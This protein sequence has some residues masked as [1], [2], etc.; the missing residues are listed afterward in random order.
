MSRP[1]VSMVVAIARNGVIGR[2][3]DLPWHQS[4][5]LRRF[6]AI[7]M[8]KPMLMGRKCFDSFGGR[9]LPG[10]P[11][12][13]ITRNKNFS[14]EGVQAVYSFEEGM[15]KA[16]ALAAETGADEICVIGGGE[17]Y[18]L[19]M[20]IADILHITHIDADIEGDTVFPQIDP[21]LWQ[22]EEAGSLPAGEKDDYPVR[23]VTY[24]RREKYQ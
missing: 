12:V 1:T 11:H 16:E 23:F 19:A 3:G 4:S 7:T 8:G 14:F 24:T 13:V 20:D 18:R 10:R 21:A 5:D 9:T 17:I 22:G 6:K 2:D 15:Q